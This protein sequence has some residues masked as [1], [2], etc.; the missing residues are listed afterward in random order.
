[1]TKSTILLEKSTRKR[2]SSFGRHAET[3]DD[4]IN[5]VL[6]EVEKKE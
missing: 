6:D 3:Y 4:I 5:R 1:M 2:L